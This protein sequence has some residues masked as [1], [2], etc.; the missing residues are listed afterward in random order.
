MKAKLE[1]DL[2]DFDDRLEHLRCVKSMDLAL[3]L[4]ELR[5]NSYRTIT[6]GYGD[7]DSFVKGVDAVYERLE[8]LL[9]EHDIN[10]EKL[11]V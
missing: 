8:E 1:F 6:N 5:T 11:I 9:S 3:V 2:T 7:D 4:W 10:I